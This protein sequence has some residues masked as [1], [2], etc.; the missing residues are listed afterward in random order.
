[1]G[2]GVPKGGRYPGVEGYPEGKGYPGGGGVPRQTRMA[3]TTNQ[4][5]ENGTNSSKG[6]KGDQPVII[7]FHLQKRKSG[8]AG[9]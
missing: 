2:G 1:M 4:G 6:N 3:L 8:G 9:D 5:N 7:I